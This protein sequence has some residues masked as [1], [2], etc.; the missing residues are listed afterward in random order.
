MAK[1]NPNHKARF[2]IGVQCYCSC[3]WSSAMWLN[4]GAKASASAEWREHRAKCEAIEQQGKD[5][6]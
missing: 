4:K 2:A 3:G 6:T 5:N 1:T